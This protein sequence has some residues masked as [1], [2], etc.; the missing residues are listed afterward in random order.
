MHRRISLAGPA[1]NPTNAL[2]LRRAARRTVRSE[3][4]WCHRKAPARPFHFGRRKERT[5]RFSRVHCH[6][7]RLNVF[8]WRTRRRTAHAATDRDVFLRAF[9]N[10]ALNA[11]HDGALLSASGARLAMTTDTYV[12]NPVIFPGG[13]IGNLAVN[14]TVNDLAMCGARAFALSAGFILE[15]VYRWKPCAQWC[16]QCRRRRKPPTSR[17]SPETPKL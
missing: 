1:Q 7:R 2:P 3:R 17:S 14:G 9:S 13:T 12:V 11:R 15:E 16:P 8:C 10:S 4:R 6:G 5:W